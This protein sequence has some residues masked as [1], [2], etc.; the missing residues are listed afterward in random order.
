MFEV[1][2]ENND[3]FGRCKVYE[4]DGKYYMNIMEKHVFNIEER[5]YEHLFWVYDQ[6]FISCEL[7]DP[8]I[9]D[10][11]KLKR[12]VVIKGEKAYDNA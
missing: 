3:Y 8:V 7:Y 4:E 1:Y 9:H 6:A 5:V 11:N 12:F 10:G 2:T